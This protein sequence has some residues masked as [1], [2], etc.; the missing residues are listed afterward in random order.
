LAD[1]ADINPPLHP[2]DIEALGWAPNRVAKRPRVAAYLAPDQRIAFSQWGFTRYF[3]E[4]D[5]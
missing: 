1:N 4:L 3:K 5:G 2:A